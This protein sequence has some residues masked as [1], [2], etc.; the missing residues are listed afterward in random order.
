MSVERLLA[1]VTEVV[2]LANEV[3]AGDL[4]K[5]LKKYADSMYRIVLDDCVRIQRQKL[6]TMPVSTMP[7]PALKA[8]KVETV[9]SLA[10][11]AARKLND[12]KSVF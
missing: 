1:A 2:K 12:Q 6:P 4:Q 8:S 5:Q 9:P 3:K 10:D 11:A 7:A